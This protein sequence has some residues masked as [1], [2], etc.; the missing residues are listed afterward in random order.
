MK[1]EREAK[2]VQEF[3]VLYFDFAQLRAYPEVDLISAS[4]HPA[5][6]SS[7]VLYFL[8]NISTTRI[9]V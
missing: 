3:R 6:R 4:I 5:T 8:V 1:D 9:H 7:I 2:P